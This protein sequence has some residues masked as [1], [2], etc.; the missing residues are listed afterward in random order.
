MFRRIYL[1]GLAAL[2]LCV[3]STA[4][5]QAIATQGT[6]NIT[7]AVSVTPQ[8]LDFIPPLGSGVGTVQV[9]STGTGIFA[10]ALGTSGQ[11]LDIPYAPGATQPGFL[12]LAAVPGMTFDLTMLEAGAFKSTKCSSNRPAAGQTCTPAGSALSLVNTSDHS[13]SVSISL[14]GNFRNATGDESPYVGV[15]TFQFADRNFQQLLAGFAAGDFPVTTFS[16]SFAPAEQPA[17]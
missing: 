11:I 6:L 15:I 7:G 9:G 10:T 3:C 5:G 2:F 13:C 17:P 16:A 14:S 1:Q 8:S 4:Q 12:T